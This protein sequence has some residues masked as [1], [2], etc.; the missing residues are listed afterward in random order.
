MLSS[1]KI[2]P[3]NLR[4]SIA[5]GETEVNQEDDKRREIDF[6]PDVNKYVVNKM[7]K[8]HN[9]KFAKPS[10]NSGHVSPSKLE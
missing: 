5:V 8:F 2:A 1:P 9:S 6:G 10:V 3:K 4:N 7:R